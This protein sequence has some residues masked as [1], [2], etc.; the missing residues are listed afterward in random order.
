MPSWYK[1]KKENLRCSTLCGLC[2]KYINV[3]GGGGGWGGCFPYMKLGYISQHLF[4]IR[5]HFYMFLVSDNF[6][7]WQMRYEELQ[8]T[9][10]FCVMVLG[11]NVSTFL[12]I[13]EFNVLTSI[14]YFEY[15]SRAII[16]FIFW[17]YRE[18]FY[19]VIIIPWLEQVC[20]SYIYIL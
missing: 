7:N 1:E 20:H 14:L 12:F 5:L 15:M 9:H 6:K 8:S 17:L 13:I 11:L 10:P 19:L 3:S 4:E 16:A 2:C 18:H